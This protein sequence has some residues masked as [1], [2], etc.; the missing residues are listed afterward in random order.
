MLQAMKFAFSSR[1]PAAFVSMSIVAAALAAC[2]SSSSSSSSGATGDGGSGGS[3][4][5]GAV[6]TCKAYDPCAILPAADVGTALGAG[7]GAGALTDQSNGDVELKLCNWT[8]ELVPDGGT[9]GTKRRSNLLLRCYGPGDNDPGT[10]R[11]TLQGLYKNVVDVPGVGD[12]AIW[13]SGGIGSTSTTTLSGQLDVFV[14]KSIYFII[15]VS[16]PF[17]DATALA[18]AKQLAL[19]VVPKL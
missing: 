3:S 6:G 16:G 11:T 2:S 12:T 4:S 5:G 19:E 9:V 7:V 8:Q 14:G 13:G 1:S 15:D 10:A 17:D 18:A